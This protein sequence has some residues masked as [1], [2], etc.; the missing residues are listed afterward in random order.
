[1]PTDIECGLNA[2][3]RTVLLDY[4]NDEGKI[5]SLQM[6]NKTPNFK[7]NIFLNACNYIIA[8]FKGEK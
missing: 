8:D 2:G 5:K 1:M 6:K 3:L 4:K 7:T